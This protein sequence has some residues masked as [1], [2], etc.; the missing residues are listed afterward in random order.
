[1]NAYSARRYTPSEVP[2]GSN[3]PTEFSRRWRCR[4]LTTSRSNARIS[5]ACDGRY[6]SDEGRLKNHDRAISLTCPAS[7]PARSRRGWRI[8]DQRAAQRAR[9]RKARLGG[10]W[11]RSTPKSTNGFHVGF[12]DPARLPGIRRRAGAARRAGLGAHQ[13]GISGQ[14]APRSTTSRKRCGHGGAERW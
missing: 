11:R 10:W 13:S 1:M 12:K 2:A 7:A 6:S 3:L 4:C 14:A 9:S 5:S 8:R